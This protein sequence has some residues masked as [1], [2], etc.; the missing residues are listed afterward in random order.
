V[1]AAVY[2]AIETIAG[3]EVV[4]V[5]VTVTQV[6]VPGDEDDEADAVAA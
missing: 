2:T 1:R 5:S 4:G 3:M 6:H